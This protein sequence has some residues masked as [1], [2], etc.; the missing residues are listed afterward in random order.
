M[1]LNSAGYLVYDFIISFFIVKGTG[2]IAYQ[3]YCHHVLAAIAFYIVCYTE[4][5]PVMVSVLTLAVE[6]STVFLNLRWFTFELN[7]ESSV[8]PAINSILIFTSY[9][10]MR[11]IG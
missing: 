6:A 11:I 4:G 8:V 10:V 7:I 3:T 2:I 1:I 9:L 5:A